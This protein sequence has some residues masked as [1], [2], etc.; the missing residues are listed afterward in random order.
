M[1]RKR[2]KDMTTDEK[3]D[4]NIKGIE[5]NVKIIVIGWGII[6]VNVLIIVVLRLV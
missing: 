5:R 3:I 2:Y 1:S 4:H 6:L